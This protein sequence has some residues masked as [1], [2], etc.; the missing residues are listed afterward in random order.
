MNRRLFII[1]GHPC[2]SGGRQLTTEEIAEEVIEGN[3]SITVDIDITNPSRTT[4][5]WVVR[6]SVSA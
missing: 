5:H 6:D 2:A 3:L 1:D 4:S